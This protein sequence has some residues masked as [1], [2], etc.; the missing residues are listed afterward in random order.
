MSLWQILS[1]ILKF[2]FVS[3]NIILFHTII[4]LLREFSALAKISGKSRPKLWYEDW[5]SGAGCEKAIWTSVSWSRDNRGSDEGCKSEWLEVRKRA[6]YVF[7]PFH[8]R[9]RNTERLTFSGTEISP[10]WFQYFLQRLRNTYMI[11]FFKLHSPSFYRVN[12]KF[13]FLSRESLLKSC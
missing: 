6:Q 5:R 8:R 7:I 12:V 4:A 13:P 2:V 1:L 11:Q 10:R 9:G 3:I